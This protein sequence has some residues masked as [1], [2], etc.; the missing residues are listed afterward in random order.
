MESMNRDIYLITGSG[1][2]VGKSLTKQ[3]KLDLDAIFI[4]PS[5]K[6]LDL[7]DYNEVY[8]FLK[9]NNINK[10]VHLA[11]SMS[12]IGELTNNPLKYLE[13]NFLINFNIVKAALETGVK[14][15]VTFGS[16]CSYSKDTIIPMKEDHLWKGKPEN[17]YG[18]SKLLLLEHLAS[19]NKM[20]WLYL[21]PA[22]IYGVGDHFSSEK[23]H[24]IPATILKFQNALRNN[25]NEIE[26][27]GNGEQVRD[28]IY[29][30]DLCIITSEFIKKSYHSES[31]INVSTGMG[32]KIKDII[33]KIRRYMELEHINIAWQE[34]KPIGIPIKVV[35]NSSL[36]E[37]IKEYNFITIDEGI[38]YTI[39]SLNIND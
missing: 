3:L 12:G 17:T 1:G 32:V 9:D 22:N 13:S 2:F 38:K 29:I 15:F 37:K 35:D 21:M 27:W 6:E 36:L 26:V 34:D 20:K 28:F 16:T 39:E 7:T 14:Y 24:V 5:S 30:K 11:A 33:F 25:E 8:R 4:T 18:V 19:Q 23:A 10:I 31:P